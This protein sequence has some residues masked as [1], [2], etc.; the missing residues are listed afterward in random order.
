MKKLL[1]LL[2]VVLNFFFGFGQEKSQV[3]GK[4]QDPNGV[5]IELVEVIARS[6]SNKE[7]EV[8]EYTL[9][10]GEFEL[11]LENGT[12]DL[13]FDNTLDPKKSIQIIVEQNTTL[14]PVVLESAT[15]TPK[16]DE[17]KISDINLV[18]RK[19]LIT[20]E[21]GKT[22]YNV[23]QDPLTKGKTVADALGNVPS[24]GVDA[25]GSVTLRGSSNVKVLING[26]PSSM[27]GVGNATSGLSSL[28]A[29]MVESVEVITS[30]SAKYDADGEGGVIN[31]VLK[32]NNKEGING[33]VEAGGGYQPKAFVNTQLGVNTKAANWN[34]GA[35]FRHEE[36]LLGVRYTAQALDQGQITEKLSQ[37][38]TRLKNRN[39]LYATAGVDFSI[40]TLNTVNFTLGMK[41]LWANNYRDIHFSSETPGVSTSSWMRNE[42]E[43]ED[44]N[45]IDFGLSLTHLTQKK[46]EK[47]TF[48]ANSAFMN[49]QLNSDITETVSPRSTGEAIYTSSDEKQYNGQ[50]SVDYINPQLPFISK[51]FKL[52]TG[53]KYD[54]MLNNTDFSV[55]NLATN[56]YLSDFTNDV[57]YDQ[58]VASGYVMG[59]ETFGKWTTSGGLRV[60]N[61]DIDLSYQNSDTNIH[62][63]YT[64]FF[65]SLQALYNQS[66]KTQLR[67]AY[68]KR[69]NRP[70]ARFLSPFNSYSDNKNIFVGNPDL[71]PTY[72]HS[73]E[74][75]AQ[76]KI[77][78][79]TL[80]PV[81]FYRNTQDFISVIYLPDSVDPTVFVATPRNIG[82]NQSYGLENTINFP[83][84]S[85]WNTITTFTVFG[86]SRDAS[87]LNF[88]FS[89]NG[90]SANLTH[91]SN[92]KLPNGW[93]LTARYMFNGPDRDNTN[94]RKSFS[95]FDLAV[96]KELLNGK[97][98]IGLN[99]QNIF[100]T[101]YRSFE[102]TTPTFYRDVH[103]QMKNRQ[104]DLVFVYR[105]G[106][107]SK[108]KNQAPKKPA[109]EDMDGGF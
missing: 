62:K 54:Q 52:E 92:L 19:K 4:V 25:D 18:A 99:A 88:D 105:F 8:V 100:N 63:N 26:K 102:V 77:G 41:N 24:V 34:F 108:Q 72:T 37:N 68:S 94:Q 39:T 90:I 3:K 104:I 35:G 7:V 60:E 14:P 58:K 38:S 5:G 87:Y 84:T 23:A 69:I 48:S 66:D 76:T 83:L 78:K 50:V 53:A 32:K 81:V 13:T 16:R 43:D 33:S 49:A 59:T 106:Q 79:A 107:T 6:S 96:N 42:A 44:N 91:R 17:L 103:M 22:V 67:F 20:Q 95:S 56:A 86:Y 75:G 101:M 61:T 97:A 21:V 80:S 1:T 15:N 51:T 65:P 55:L 28:P 71:D 30:A 47:I 57:I 89:G 11:S 9:E 40:D 70:F 10:T 64:N 36:P 98:S 29:D 109:M 12:Y 82:V 31:I 85:K 73:F 46:G 93:D 2:M 27:V 45:A 74:V